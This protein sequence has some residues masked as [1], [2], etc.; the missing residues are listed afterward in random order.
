MNINDAKI[1]IET[2]NMTLVMFDIGSHCAEW[3]S[4]VKIPDLDLMVMENFH[5]STDIHPEYRQWPHAALCLSAMAP[6]ACLPSGELIHMPW[7]WGA[8]TGEYYDLLEP[9]REGWE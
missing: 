2:D 6:L 3:V 4:F 5:L 9:M 1:K 8:G 7:P